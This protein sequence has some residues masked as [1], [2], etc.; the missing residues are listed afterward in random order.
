MNATVRWKRMQGDVG[1]QQCPAESC[2]NY[3][4]VT[5]HTRFRIIGAWVARAL[6][7]PMDEDALQI[8]EREFSK[9]QEAHFKV[10][11][12]I[13]Q[14]HS[15]DYYS[16]ARL[17]FVW[18]LVTVARLHYS[19][20]LTEASGKEQRQVCNGEGSRAT[21]GD[22]ATISLLPVLCLLPGFL[23][24]ITIP[25]SIQSGHVIKNCSFIC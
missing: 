22:A 23:G 25:N 1:D 6:P 17:G 24:G 15:N 16:P 11:L 3:E 19:R 7:N 21:S 13:D 14:P 18:E 8:A 9:L 5:F 20:A 2:S 12:I 10:H 4:S